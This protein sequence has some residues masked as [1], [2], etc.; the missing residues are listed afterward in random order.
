MQQI[1]DGSQEYDGNR[2]R[3]VNRV[4]FDPLEDI[5]HLS[6]VKAGCSVQLRIDEDS[7]YTSSTTVVLP[8]VKEVP[9]LKGIDVSYGDTEVSDLIERCALN[10]RLMPIRD[11]LGHKDLAGILRIVRLSNV[12]C[13][14]LILVL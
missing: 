4:L 2:H 11:H 13:E 7:I 10:I 6:H 12:E 1:S 9:D 14:P 5:R 3:P 8:V